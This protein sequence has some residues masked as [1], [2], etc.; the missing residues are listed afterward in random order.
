MIRHDMEEIRCW[1]SMR[2]RHTNHPQ[3]WDPATG[4][5]GVVY[6]PGQEEAGY[7]ACLV[8]HIVRAVSLWAC[9]MGKA[10]MKIPRAAQIG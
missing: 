9:R 2:C 4:T 8:F 6:H 1:P 10:V 7:T 5:N 3:K